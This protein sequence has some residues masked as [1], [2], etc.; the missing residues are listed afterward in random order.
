MPSHLGFHLN[1]LA[2]AAAEQIPIGP[3]A[4]PRPSLASHLCA[5]QSLVIHEWRMGWRAFA[6][7]K[8]LQLKRKN[9][10][11]LPNAWD[12]KGKQ[13]S[14]LAHDI[15]MFSRFTRLVS[16]HAPTGE[17]RERFF[18]SKP[19]GCTCFAEFQT[20][21]HLLVECPKYSSKFSSMIAFNKTLNNTYKI[22][23]YLKDNPNAFTFVDEPIDIFEPPLKVDLV[24]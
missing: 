3:P 2:D 20:R 15:M 5:N 23:R 8:E 22:F 24:I 11:Y 17:Y 6:E 7:S 18:P 16:G 9:R 13:F 12:G 4:F 14:N 21:S 10:L 1:E 19:R